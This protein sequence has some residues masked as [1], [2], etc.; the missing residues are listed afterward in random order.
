M[1]VSSA[2][3]TSASVHTGWPCWVRT[4]AACVCASATAPMCSASRRA[5]SSLSV[6]PSASWT[7]STAGVK[8][9][10]TA[11]RAT[12]R[13]NPDETIPAPRPNAASSG[14]APRLR[15]AHQ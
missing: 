1:V 6:A 8:G 2:R 12:T 7:C 14:A 5:V 11:A 15:A 3:W 4:M 13:V 10:S 9:A